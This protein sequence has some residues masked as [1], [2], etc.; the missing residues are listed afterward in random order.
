MKIDIDCSFNQF[1]SDLDKSVRQTMENPT[2]TEKQKRDLARQ[3]RKDGYSLASTVYFDDLK[4][5]LAQQGVYEH[6]DEITE[7]LFATLATQK[8]RYNIFS[9]LETLQ[10]IKPDGLSH[11]RFIESEILA[12]SFFN[13]SYQLKKYQLFLGF[14]EDEKIN[15]LLQLAF[16]I[17]PHAMV[18]EEY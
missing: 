17:V 2:L 12:K 11:E 18:R 13:L 10:L 4:A 9:N 16:H 3:I 5:M 6:L 8:I 1:A 14:I 7:R 15:E